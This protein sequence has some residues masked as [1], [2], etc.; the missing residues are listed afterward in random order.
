LDV[1]VIFIGSGIFMKERATP[2]DVEND[3]KEREEAVSRAKASSKPPPT[4]TPP[5]FSPR[6]PNRSPAP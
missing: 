3:P 4:T 5:R 6:S 2:F 1:E